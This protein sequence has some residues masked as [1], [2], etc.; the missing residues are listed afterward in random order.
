VAIAGRRRASAEDASVVARYGGVE[1]IVVLPHAEVRAAGQAS[2]GIQAEVWKPCRVEGHELVVTASIGIALSPDDGNSLDSLLQ[3]ANAA[4]F[5]AKADGRDSFRFFSSDMQR[6]S[7]RMLQLE[8][9]LRWAIPRHELRVVYQPQVHIAT[10]RVVGVEALVR[11]DHPELG[12]IS[13][14][15]FIP[16][17]E[18]SGQM[19]EIGAWILRTALHQA[20]R[21]QNEG[22]PELILAVNLSLQ[23]FRHESLLPN[24]DAALLESGFPTGRL[25]LEL[26]ESIA[27]DDPEQAVRIVQA[28]R[29]RGVLLS[30]DD[31]GTGYS[32][33]SYLKRLR[34][35]KLKI[36]KSFIDDIDR[37]GTDVSIVT[38]IVGM[39]QGLGMTTIAEGVETAGQLEVLGRLGCDEVQGYLFS[40]PLAAEEM[41]DYLRGAG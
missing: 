40:K 2:E 41:E 38:A 22:L 36:D 15:E 3:C 31:F 19:V 37:D 1:F 26:T 23:Q 32:S 21:W 8:N 39:A 10:R 13:P 33:L 18:N 25:E 14:A 16:V 11:W 27:M 29:E 35:N 9:A 6:H 28:L 4:A 5:Q 7:S 20:R 12:A 17:A 34:L 24:L 30:I